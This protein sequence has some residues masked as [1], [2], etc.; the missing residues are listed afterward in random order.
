MSKI[1][2]PAA[3]FKTPRMWGQR[4]AENSVAALGRGEEERINAWRP[5]RRGGGHDDAIDSFRSGRDGIKILGGL[6][7]VTI[8]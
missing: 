5:R 8:E 7:N 3:S 6:I 1:L 2:T 4:I